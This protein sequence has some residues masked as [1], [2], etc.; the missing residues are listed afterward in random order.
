[1][2]PREFNAVNLPENAVWL[3]QQ[4]ANPWIKLVYDFG[5]FVHRGMTLEA[6]LDAMLPHTAF[7]HRHDTVEENGRVQFVVPGESRQIDYPALFRRLDQAGYRGDACC[8]VSSM[9]F[10]KT[11]LRSVRGGRNLCSEHDIGLTPGRVALSAPK[12]APVVSCKDLSVA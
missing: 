8:E 11:G 6:T 7:V 4:V 12:I 9:V 10:K 5:H 2:G 1:M 3:V